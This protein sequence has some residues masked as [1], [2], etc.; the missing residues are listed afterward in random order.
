MA[1]RE[2][3]PRNLGWKTAD[4]LAALD[5]HRDEMGRI[6]TRRQSYVCAITGDEHENYLTPVPD[7]DPM[8]AEGKGNVRV[9]FVGDRALEE[10]QMGA[11]AKV[12]ETAGEVLANHALDL[13]TAGSS[14]LFRLLTGKLFGLR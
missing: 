6:R 8:G 14:R 7:Y 13:V 9:V 1:R 4:E 10:L 5:L 12:R 11:I 2:A 3:F